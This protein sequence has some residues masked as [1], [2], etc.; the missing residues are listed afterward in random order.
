VTYTRTDEP[1]T[2]LD[3]LCGLAEAAP[4][5]AADQVLAPALADDPGGLAKVPSALRPAA[6]AAVALAITGLLGFSL[7]ELLVDG[8]REHHDLTASARRTLARPGST[9]FVQL[10]THQITVTRQPRIDVFVNGDVVATVEAEITVVFVISALIAGV[11][12]GRLTALHSGRCD[13]TGTLVIGGTEVLTRQ[14]RID[15]SGAIAL[16]EGIR[17]LPERYYAR[18]SQ[19]PGP[20]AGE[21]AVAEGAATQTMRMI[22][23]P[24]ED[25]G[26]SA[27]PP[28]TSQR[29][30][31]RNRGNS[32]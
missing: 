6:T 29:R 3:L 13:I 10:A 22:V 9:E 11:H 4:K 23:L 17:L 14:G 12:G 18:A 28:V 20:E 2:G 16:H 19:E 15:P 30:L 21:I 5:T 1:R 27:R 24:D 32:D 7:A 31:P 26:A 8:W 25:A